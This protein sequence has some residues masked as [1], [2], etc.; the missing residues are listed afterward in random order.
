VLLYLLLDPFKV[1]YHYDTYYESGKPAYVS[2]NKE[3]VAVE[4][5]LN[6]YSKYRYN[7]FILGNSRTMFYKVSSWK[8]HVD[9]DECFHFNATGES[10][11]GIYNKIK[12]LDAKNVKIKHA[13]IILDYSTLSRVKNLKRH[14]QLAHPLLSGQSRFDFQLDFFKTF[15][16]KDFLIAY[17]DFKISNKMK[18]YMKGFL[19]DKPVEYNLKYNEIQMKYLD[20]IL[21]QNDSVFYTSEKMKV[22]YK[23][24]TIQKISPAIIKSQQYEMLK[25]ISNT[26]QKHNSY[27][28]I[29]I[30]PLYDQ[31]RLNGQDKERLIELFGKSNVYDFSGINSFTN[32]YHNYYEDSHY[33]PH[34]ADSIINKIYSNK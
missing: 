1:L 17:L 16:S 12:F 34:I 10:L 31:K 13:L 18:D 2:L 7:A 5:F 28:K 24:D 8:K 3:Y 23:R 4:T 19:E 29:I 9:S 32:D 26:L 27:F 14:L 15:V 11:Y 22:F 25:Q 30:N 6:N 21:E 20:D 33:R